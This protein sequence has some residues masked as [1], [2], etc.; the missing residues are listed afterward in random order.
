MCRILFALEILPGNLIIEQ[1]NLILVSDSLFKI[2]EPGAPLVDESGK[3]AVEG[4]G[5][6]AGDGAQYTFTGSQEEIALR[7]IPLRMSST[8]VLT[9]TFTT[10]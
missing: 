1:R 4:D 9:L 7:S 3:I 5:F 2:Y 10:W 8:K 6:L